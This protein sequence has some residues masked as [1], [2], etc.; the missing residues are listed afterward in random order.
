MACSSAS[1]ARYLGNRRSRSRGP[2]QPGE[3]FPA[4][5]ER[6]DQIRDPTAIG[7]AVAKLG[8]DVAGLI[9]QSLDLRLQPAFD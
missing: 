5:K 3:R 9:N 8:E 6:L 7:A 1:L 4:G 2:Q